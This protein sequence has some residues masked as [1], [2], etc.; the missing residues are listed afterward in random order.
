[1]AAK[2]L[3]IRSG[4]FAV[5]EE[6]VQA[7]PEPSGMAPV[8]AAPSGT[9][10]AGA[11]PSGPESTPLGPS[12]GGVAPAGAMPDS[13]IS[14]NTMSHRGTSPRQ[15]PPLRET[16]PVQGVLI[17]REAR[18]LPSGQPVRAAPHGPAAHGPAAHGPAARV[19]ALQPVDA[20]LAVD[21]SHSGGAG[22]RRKFASPSIRSAERRRW[23]ADLLAPDMAGVLLH[24]AGGIGKS[25]L[26]AQ[27]VA[28]VVRLEPGRL[29]VTF[30]GEVSADTFLA[31]LASTLR[32]HPVAASRGGARALASAGRTDLSWGHRL[33]LFRDH[34]LGQVPVLVVLDDFDDNLSVRSAKPAIE[35]PALAGMLANLASAPGLARLLIT[36][37]DPF[38]LPGA[39]Q[40]LGVRRA[41]PLSPSGAARL[42]AALPALSLL[43]EPD[44]DQVWRLTGGHPRNMEYLDA[45][46]AGGHAGFAEVAERLAAAIGARTGQASLRAP[47]DAPAPGSPAAAEKVASVAGDVLLGELCA[48]LSPAAH[49]LLTGASVYREPASSH[50][51]LLPA[52][53]PRQ[54]AGLT[55][56]VAECAAAGLLTADYSGELPSV[57]VHRWTA[58]ELH[59]RL[60]REQRGEEV[61][62]AHRRAAEYWRWR[63]SSW[64]HDRHALHEASY[65]LLQAGE[66]G[67][68]GRSGAR[69][70][71][72]RRLTVLGAAALAVMVAAG[73]T[74]AATGA[75]SAPARTSGPA[76]AQG[77]AATDPLAGQPAAVRGQAAAWVARQVSGDAIVSCDPA[78]YAALQAYG[79]PPGNLLVL[80][81]SSADP[82]GSDLVMATPAVRNQF[83]SRLVS[84][85]APVIIASFGTGDMRIDV[86][87]AAPGGAAAYRAA[88][89]TDLAARRAAGSE[90]L[91]N[92]RLG[93]SPAARSDL[94]AGQVDSRLLLM[95]AAVVNIEP[96][97]VTAFTDSGPRAA[98]GVPLRAADLAVLAQAGSANGT[99]TGSANSATPGGAHGPG[100]ALQRVL[101]FVRAQRPPY[102][103]ARAAIVRGRTGPP[104]ISVEFGAPSLTG[105]LQGRPLTGRGPA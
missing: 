29:T 57:F 76:T 28:R 68:R 88:L 24:G 102:R 72:A 27:I 65:H 41:G 101:T 53:Q 39:G 66:E 78:M 74:A 30:S 80:R 34:V 5:P 75:F 50:V 73:V 96:V 23:C 90:L 55:A 81:P 15:G 84:V 103:P 86:R 35:D 70:G 26:A 56:L 71:T 44:V 62:D 100:S 9:A 42:A 33:D 64:P 95:L 37:R 82:L 31:R 52:G 99:A 8:E 60:S 67:Q 12:S 54:A 104:L 85:Y 10:H 32:R 61:A 6:M 14:D 1:V 17:V 36:C 58:A 45:L 22:P 21:A 2:I 89:A 77:S 47:A 20:D 18:P 69:R 63:I 83:G 38:E 4:K 91:H 25:A 93:L 3:S 105:L 97:R 19:P 87:A 59:R 51:L 48:R 7:G 79:I 98:H 40:A 94:A 92:P 49:D 43:D 46:L 16:L 13:A 11:V